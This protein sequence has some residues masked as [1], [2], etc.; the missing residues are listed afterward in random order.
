MQLSDD[1]VD[2]LLKNQHDVLSILEQLE[3]RLNKL[4]FL[5]SDAKNSLPISVNPLVASIPHHVDQK[6]YHQKKESEIID[7]ITKLIKVK[8]YLLLSILYIICIKY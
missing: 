7:G 1:G 3:F 2:L 5:F 4:H 8:L 6:K